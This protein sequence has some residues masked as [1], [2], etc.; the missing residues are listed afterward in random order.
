MRRPTEDDED[1]ARF[2]G[3]LPAADSVLLRCAGCGCWKKPDVKDIS[4]FF[5]YG[6]HCYVCGE[7]ACEKWK[8]TAK[9][10]EEIGEIEEQTRRRRGAVGRTGRVRGEEALRREYHLAVRRSVLEEKGQPGFR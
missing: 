10:F 7:D 8:K 3:G 1:V 5:K 4:I 2:I 9:A 6:G